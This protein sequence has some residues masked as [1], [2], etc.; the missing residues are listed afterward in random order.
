M[1]KILFLISACLLQFGLNA[2]TTVNATGGE[3]TGGNV[4]MS[5]SIGEVVYTTVSNTS[6]TITQGEQQ[7]YIPPFIF[8]INASSPI[9]CEGENT[10]ISITIE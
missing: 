2:Q 3:A 6:Y 10:T 4:Q 7:P 5:F 9:I 8:S 1:K